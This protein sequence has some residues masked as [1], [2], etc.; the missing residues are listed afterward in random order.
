V[1]VNGGEN[2]S[3][4]TIRANAEKV[5]ILFNKT[6]SFFVALFIAE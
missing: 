2:P 6:F 3:P 5:Y 4:S 1:K